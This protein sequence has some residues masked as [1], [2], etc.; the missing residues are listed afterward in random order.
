VRFALVACVLVVAT[1]AAAQDVPVIESGR[2]AEVQALFAPH[3]L[4]DEIEGARFMSIAIDVDRITLGV[5]RGEVRWEAVLRHPEHP[6][7][8]ARETASFAI[9]SA[10]DPALE[11][12]LG[13]LEDNDEGRFWRT[14]AAPPDAMRSQARFDYARSW[15][16]DGVVWTALLVLLAFGLAMHGLERRALWTLIG[17]VAVG[18]ALRLWLS[19][20]ALLG[21]WPFSRTKLMQRAV[22]EGPALR[23]LSQGRVF[24]EIGVLQSVGLVFACV[25]PVAVF[26]HAR[27]LLGDVRPAL[28]A[29]AVVAVLPVHL[30]FSR[31]E[32]AFVPS[33]VLS[34]LLFALAH[35]SVKASRGARLGLLSVIVPVSALACTARPL[36]I[37][38]LPV[39][40]AALLLL[41]DDERGE[42]WRNPKRWAPLLVAT[43]AGGAAAVM[44]LRS[45]YAREVAE[46][47]SFDTVVRGLQVIFDVEDDTL[48]NPWITPPL[49]LLVVAFGAWRSERR[50]VVLLFGWLGLFFVTHAY[51]VPVSPAMQARY[52]LHLVVPFAF[53][54]A[55]GVDALWR[56]RRI[57]A[58]AAIGYAAT[59]PFVHREFVQDLGFNDLREQVFLARALPE[60]PDGCT[61]LEY[62]R[63][64]VDLRVRRFAS[65]LRDGRHRRRLV[66]WNVRGEG[67]LREEVA[68]LL[69]TPPECLY[70]YRGLTCQG[71]SGDAELVAECRAME[72]RGTVVAEDRFETRRYDA[73]QSAGIDGGE[74]VELSLHRIR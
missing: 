33:L 42:G 52:H 49:L 15:L 67:A 51:V 39:L 56:R 5:D 27:H 32:V 55:L 10:E 72:R 70:W 62:N 74:I 7:A 6:E 58:W 20:E 9:T 18:V 57:L 73:N 50:R 28:F 61:V 53:L 1:G 60:V 64:D 41:G 65:E 68:T 23:M 44:E 3:A 30:R 17:I 31:S 11:A 69:D 34:S 63:R 40:A 19:P 48:L 46:G 71:E 4:G 13:A 2:D 8:G 24:P 59:S 26:A 16:R 38:F 54:V 45:D 43:V 12:L 29:A 35:A 25:T 47:A 37:L 22:W 66:V 21:A 14:R 36:N